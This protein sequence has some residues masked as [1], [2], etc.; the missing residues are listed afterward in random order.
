MLYMFICRERLSNF[1]NFFSSD[2]DCKLTVKINQAGICQF[3]IWIY[4]SRQDIFD[5]LYF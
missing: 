5:V 4:Y 1:D 3:Q 2:S